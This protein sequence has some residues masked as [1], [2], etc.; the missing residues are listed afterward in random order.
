MTRSTRW[1]SFVVLLTAGLWLAGSPVAAD[2]DTLMRDFRVRP[3]GLKPA[4]AFS[5]KTLDGKATA[6]ADHHGHAVLL[7]FWATW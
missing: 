2:L 5:L 7:Y 6:L 4:P 3:T 1:M